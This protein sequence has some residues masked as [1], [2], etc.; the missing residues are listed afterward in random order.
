MVLRAGFEWSRSG[1]C[2]RADKATGHPGRAPRG[3]CLGHDGA[4]NAPNDP[5]WV[6]IRKVWLCW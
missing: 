3:E 2:L 5:E 6:R 1:T 4:R